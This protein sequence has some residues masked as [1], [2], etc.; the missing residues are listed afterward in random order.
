MLYLIRSVIGVALFV[1]LTGSNALA[2]TKSQGDEVAGIEL[3][4]SPVCHQVK[5]SGVTVK[6]ARVY[7]HRQDL[8][9]FLNEVGSATDTFFMKC[10]DCPCWL[11][12]RLTGE[13][14]Y[15]G[16]P[17]V[18]WGGGNIPPGTIVVIIDDGGE[19]VN[20][21]K[22]SQESS[23]CTAELCVNTK[24]E[25]SFSLKCGDMKI[26]VSTSGDVSVS[27]SGGG[28]SVSVPLKKGKQ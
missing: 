15:R 14:I 25:I 9:K 10:T 23:G 6:K 3:G 17:K 8:I 2:Q 12:A 16:A 18:S 26:D 20:V 11:E 28:A 24:G 19:F 22:A 4:T 7:G 1:L 21:Y 27:L 5:I 13:C